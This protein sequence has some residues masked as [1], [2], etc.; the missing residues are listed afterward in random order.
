MNFDLSTIDGRPPFFVMSA[1]KCWK[2]ATRFL[3]PCSSV[4]FIAA[5]LVSTAFVGARA[6]VTSP[7]TSFARSL[8]R[9]DASRLSTQPVT[10][11]DQVR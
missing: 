10:A 11:F 6:S 3:P 5:G 7:A 4:A 1:M 9:G 8:S 2:P